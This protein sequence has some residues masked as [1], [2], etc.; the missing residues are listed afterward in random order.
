VRPREGVSFT[1]FGLAEAELPATTA[2][3]H[4]LV[5]DLRRER[6]QAIDYDYSIA[7]IPGR[8]TPPAPAGALVAPGTYE[9]RL[10]VN[11]V[12]LRQPLIVEADPRGTRSA[13]E[14]AELAGVEAEVA[15]LLADSAKREAALVDLERRLAAVAK[16]PDGA[17]VGWVA[18][19]N[20]KLVAL[21]EGA[22]PRTTNGALAGLAADLESGDALPTGPQREVLAA[23]RGELE[24]FV[25]RWREF[26]RR[27]LPRLLERLS[28][29]G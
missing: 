12:T 4:R 5:W 13:A 23:S 6:P 17:P 28:R 14:L 2:G 24:R 25:G 9:V 10:T 7:A 8:E 21:R 15:R 19:A 3:H 16:R 1:G 11:G 29:G 26:E 18:E 27:D 20:R 22:D